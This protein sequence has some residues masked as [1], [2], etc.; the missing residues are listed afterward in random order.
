MQDQF[1]DTLANNTKI[2]LHADEDITSTL[3]IL[4]NKFL[5]Y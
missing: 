4:Q 2:L 1:D 5:F 3:T